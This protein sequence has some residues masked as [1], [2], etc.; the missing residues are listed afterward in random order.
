MKTSQ[1]GSIKVVITSIT[2]E[3]G[4]SVVLKVV[5]SVTQPKTSEKTIEK[6]GES[7]I[8][9]TEEDRIRNEV[10]PNLNT[11]TLSPRQR[12]HRQGTKEHEE[13][14]LALSQKGEYDPAYVTISDEEIL[15]LVEKY[16]GTGVIK[17]NS[18]N[19]S[20]NNKEVIILNNKIVGVCIDNR[21]GVSVD[22]TVFKIHYSKKGVH[23]VP[24]YPSK[25]KV[26]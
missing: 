3:N 19:L 6:S 7:G 12:I 4:I 15:A 13:R 17:I 22:T 1:T 14:K 24:D 18:K 11:G 8:I 20:W 10:I 21:T 2:R 9:K 25:K 23:I 16:K 26:T 5:I